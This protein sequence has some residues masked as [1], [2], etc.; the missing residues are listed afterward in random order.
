MWTLIGVF[1]H[2]THASEQELESLAETQA[3]VCLCPT[4]EANLG[5]GIFPLNT[6]LDRDGRVAI[7]SDSHV[8]VNP[9]EELRWIEYEQTPREPSSQRGEL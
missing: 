9:F 3:V 5:D 7:G 4:T 6:W 1:V 2:A 8:G